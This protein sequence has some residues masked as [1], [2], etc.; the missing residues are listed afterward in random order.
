MLLPGVTRAQVDPEKRRLIQF[1][2]N[3]SLQGLGPV[4]GYAFYYLNQPDWPR[5]GQT[6]RLALAPVY[7]DSEL[8]FREALGPQTDLA[9]GVAGGGFADGYSEVR[10]G[11]FLKDQSFNG[12][13]GEL[14]TSVYHLF[15][16]GSQIPLN[17][18]VRATFHHTEYDRSSRTAAGFALPP[19]TS[20]VRTRAGLRWGGSEPLLTPRVA[21]ELSA[22]HEADLRGNS[23]NYGL[24][25]DR[26]TEAQSHR[27]W[28]RGLFAYTLPE[29]GDRFSLNLT[30]GTSLNADRLNGY[31]LGAALPFSGEFPLSL[32]GYYFQEIT[33][34]QFALLG[35]LYSVPLDDQQRWHLTG[36]A[37]SAVV[38]YVRGMTQPGD[39]HSG[40]GGGLGY[41]SASQ[42]WELTLGYAYG[43]DAIRS[44]GRGAHTVGLVA[45]LDLEARRTHRRSA[46]PEL[47]P[48]KSRGLQR[49]FRGVFGD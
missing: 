37:T 41:T 8:A 44:A 4:A 26:R 46:Q 33:A 21:M 9:F 18:I 34:R 24:A 20:A 12:H 3:Q 7:L 31:K 40:L 6:L 47:G 43:V 45:Q 11:R 48:E 5:T 38:D 28:A 13:G 22:W 36:F 23:G 32:P 1:G 29:R 42:V 49:L 15:N 16:P 14:S 19:D 27:F 39:W 17:A 30:A 10:G 35:G 2:Y 25:G